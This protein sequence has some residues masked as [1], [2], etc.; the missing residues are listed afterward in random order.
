MII[1]GC[2]IRWEKGEKEKE[3][4]N[5]FFL[6]IDIKIFG[7]GRVPT[8]WSGL[9]SIYRDGPLRMIHDR[10]QHSLA[11]LKDPKNCKKKIKA[12]SLTG[13]DAALVR[14]KVQLPY[15]HRINT[16]KNNNDNKSKD[17][18]ECKA[19]SSLSL[20]G[21]LEDNLHI[22][23]ANFKRNFLLSFS[24]QKPLIIFNN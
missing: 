3:K 16:K 8:I 6:K 24:V 19:I 21:E 2:Q 18:I 20:C 23:R 4:N 11:L 14:V 7:P 9:Y 15:P 1:G 12:A 17:I 22:T 5:K 10:S 13:S